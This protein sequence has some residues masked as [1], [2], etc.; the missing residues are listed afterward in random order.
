MAEKILLALNIWLSQNVDC[1]SPRNAEILSQNRKNTDYA[2]S[3]STLT[4]I[5]PYK[6]NI[7][8]KSQKEEFCL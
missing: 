1:E 8:E 7:P 6:H 3:C 5:P 4:Q 2:A